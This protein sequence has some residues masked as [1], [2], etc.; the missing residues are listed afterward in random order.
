MKVAT[1]TK[2]HRSDSN[3]VKFH[4]P[5][6]TDQFFNPEKD[7]ETKED[8]TS[9]SSTNR[10]VSLPV[11]IDKEGNDSRS[12]VTYI[13]MPGIAHFD[14]NVENVLTS[15]S[16]LKEQI[17]TPKEIENVNEEIKTTINLM[18]LLCTTNAAS[19]TLQEAKLLARIFVVENYLRGDEPDD[20]FDEEQYTSDECEF[21]RYIETEFATYPDEYD[22][23]EE[24]S[25]HLFEEYN[26]IFWNKIYSII[27]GADAYR[28]FKQQVDY[29]RNKIIKPFG[30]SVDTAFRRI[31]IM[32]KLLEFFP[33]HSSRGKQATLEHWEDFQEKKKVTNSLKREMKYN[34]LP[35]SFH[36]RFDTLEEDWSEMS[37]DKFL[38][39]AQKCEM[40]DAKKRETSRSKSTQ[41]KKRKS[42]GDDERSTSSKK[43]YKESYTQKHGK[44]SYCHMCKLAGAP[45]WVCESH[46]SSQCKKKG[47]YEKALQGS[48][49]S[50]SSS[51][52]NKD[53]KDTNGRKREYR[54]SEDKLR[55]ELR[56]MRK[57]NKS[58]K[59]KMKQHGV[60]D[61]V[62]SV[63]SD[64]TNVSY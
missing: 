56:I 41:D 18:K 24:F 50:K 34:L 45:D 51:S 37:Y 15:I 32:A 21:Y 31:E 10:T 42:S 28:A 22:T 52:G 27:F 60:V 8:T 5:Y 6:Y 12:N 23:T 57:M 46:N 62:S 49:S 39:E 36:D 7:K 54:S 55:K 4:I 35:Q 25:T 44:K 61:D 59:K 47:Q 20:E 16:Q 58:L 19:Q 64:D 26:R 3:N 2:G 63:S 53:R 48:T 38:S 33:P 11:K 1:K 13:E 43:K 14:N 9:S 17:V 29:M 40:M 30:V